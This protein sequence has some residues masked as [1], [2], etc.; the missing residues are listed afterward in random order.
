MGSKIIDKIIDKEKRRELRALDDEQLD[1]VAGG[2][3]EEEE[4]HYLCRT[5]GV[6]WTTAGEYK[7]CIFCGSTQIVSGDQ[8]KI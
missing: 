8:A 2:T 3:G 5:C 4:V 7:V 6:P 1:M